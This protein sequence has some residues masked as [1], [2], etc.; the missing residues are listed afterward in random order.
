MRRHR[1][2]GP[3]T[4]SHAGSRS[5]GYHHREGAAGH[6]LD[7]GKTV[8]GF[9]HAE[10]AAGGWIR[11]SPCLVEAM[12]TA[13]DGDYQKGADWASFVVTDGQLVTGQTPA[14]SEAAAR[15][16]LSLL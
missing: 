4:R 15:K 6:T 13:N 5:G 10:G 9:S 12:L 2:C 3:V 8:T 11:V 7:C 1:A 16:L 14:S